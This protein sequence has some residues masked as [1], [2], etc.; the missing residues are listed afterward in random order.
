MKIDL[1]SK[2]VKKF[3][4]TKKTH[5]HLVQMLIGTLKIKRTNIFCELSL[6]NYVCLKQPIKVS[7][8][9]LAWV[10]KT[11]ARES[12]CL[13]KFGHTGL[14]S[15]W[16]STHSLEECS[17][18]RGAPRCGHL[19]LS[20]TH[21]T[22]TPAVGQWTCN[23]VAAGHQPGKDIHTTPSCSCPPSHSVC[24]SATRP[25]AFPTSILT[26]LAFSFLS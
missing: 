26:H 25:P 11:T 8:A 19:P 10:K 22:S 24:L 21:L 4:L 2:N 1:H 3:K 15:R 17:T 6:K 9:L 5:F 14:Y 20:P 7:I 23:L 18:S 12:L 13:N 16:S